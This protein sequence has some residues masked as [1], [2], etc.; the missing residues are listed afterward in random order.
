MMPLTKEIGMRMTRLALIS[1]ALISLFGCALLPT[2]TIILGG[3][4]SVIN[5]PTGAKVCGVTLPTDEK[6]P[7]G[8]PKTYC[9]VA[10]EPSR[11]VK[12]TAWNIMEK[13]K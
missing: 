12:M 1:I 10:Q 3:A 13:S 6:N 4:D 7:D 5:V 11:L 2:R 9:V 8:T